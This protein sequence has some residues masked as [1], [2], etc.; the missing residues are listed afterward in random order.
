MT[1]MILL[2]ALILIV[3]GALIYQKWSLG[4]EK[5]EG[6]TGYTD[7][8][9]T[10]C[11]IN[12]TAYLNLDGDTECCDGQVTM[13]ECI[14]KPICAL[15]TNS[16]LPPCSE[17]QKTYYQTMG[18]ELCPSGLNYYEPANPTNNPGCAN[19]L[20]EY[21]NGPHVNATSKCV[22]HRDMDSNYSDSNSC[23]NMKKLQ[24]T[25]AS[26][27]TLF[28]S[29]G[30]KTSFAGASLTPKIIGNKTIQLV[31][32]NYNKSATSTPSSC[33]YPS[34]L[35][36]MIDLQQQNG[37][38]EQSV[39]VERLQAINEGLYSQECGAAAAAYNTAIIDKSTLVPAF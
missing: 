5:R 16:S 20:N 36:L 33:Y 14:G 19:T 35:S 25:V 15:A 7:T 34:D 37:I 12:T 17:V 31:Q 30:V 4:Q 38:I 2:L 24:E 11:P 13:N 18:Q 3:I 32:V 29:G 23:Y 26:A 8:Q 10:F 22:I 28:N 1:A 21:K 9:L 27:T 6:F 39:A